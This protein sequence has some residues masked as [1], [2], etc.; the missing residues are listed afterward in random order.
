MN[1]CNL[2]WLDPTVRPHS[3][4]EVHNVPKKADSKMLALS[5]RNNASIHIQKFFDRK[6]SDEWE[7]LNFGVP[8][9]PLEYVYMYDG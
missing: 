2:G 4:F 6:S 5:R 3:F 7:K 9:C 8:F 1:L